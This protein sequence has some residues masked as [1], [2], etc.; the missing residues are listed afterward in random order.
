MCLYQIYS[1]CSS[2]SNLHFPPPWSSVF[3]E[4][5]HRDCIN[6]PPCPKILIGLSQWKASWERVWKFMLLS[7]LQ[8]TADWLRPSTEG[9]RSVQQHAFFLGSGKS[10]VPSA[11]RV[12][13]G[14][15]LS[16]ITFP[17]LC[18]WLCKQLLCQALLKLSVSSMPSV[19][20]QAPH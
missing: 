14:V 2:K 19:S 4:L 20:C 10:V 6:R 5:T 8:V 12:I 3:W 1:T 9:H 13:T 15:A 16:V 7:H 11:L 18:P 17:K